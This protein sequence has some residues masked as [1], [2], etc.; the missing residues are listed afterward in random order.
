MVI[1]GKLERALKKVVL[2]NIERVKLALKNNDIEKAI[3]LN[4]IT[5]RSIEFLLT[6]ELLP[7]ELFSIEYADKDI[8]F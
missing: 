5:K 4:D 6:G 7:G 1:D 8:I 3:T 2:Q